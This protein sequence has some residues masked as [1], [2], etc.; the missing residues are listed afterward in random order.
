MK[1]RGQSRHLCVRIVSVRLQMWV[2]N[3]DG[4]QMKATIT[5][6]DDNVRILG[7][8]RRSCA[9]QH[10]AFREGPSL[11]E[12]YPGKVLF[13]LGKNLAQDLRIRALQKKITSC[14]SRVP[15]RLDSHNLWLQ[16]AQRLQPLLSHLHSA[17][18]GAS[19]RHSRAIGNFFLG[20]LA[21]PSRASNN[22]C[23]EGGGV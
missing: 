14:T 9:T 11:R 3:H 8:Y 18:E 2:R 6:V 21:T 4:L 1:K 12:R 5:N 17:L 19:V 15:D 7:R 10:L 20:L 13:E 16:L 23:I 22:G